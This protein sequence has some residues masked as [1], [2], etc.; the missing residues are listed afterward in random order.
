MIEAKQD[1]ILPN[2]RKGPRTAVTALA[3]SRHPNFGCRLLRQIWVGPFTAFANTGETQS[4]LACGQ[5]LACP[6][7]WPAGPCGKKGGSGIIRPVLCACIFPG[8]GLQ[9]V[10]GGQESI[11]HP[12]YEFLQTGGGGYE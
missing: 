3:A 10:R 5:G 11:W 2:L 8:D 7:A 1:E 9:K 12:C 6:V 4:P